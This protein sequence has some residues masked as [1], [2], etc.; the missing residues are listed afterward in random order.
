MGKFLT[1]PDE[2]IAATG[3]IEGH[4]RSRGYKIQMEKRD[5]AYPYV[6]AFTAN[7]SHTSVIVEIYSTIDLKRIDQWGRY[8]R[9]CTRD[10][11]FAACVPKGTDIPT[12]TLSAMRENGIGLYTS[13]H[14][15]SEIL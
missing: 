9:S 11:R 13:N 2:L 15:I 3:A 5:L 7:R 4:F 14:N 12:E 10:T 6:P 8:C 1:I